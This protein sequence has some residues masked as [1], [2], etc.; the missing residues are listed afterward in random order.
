MNEKVGTALMIAVLIILAV[1]L[2]MVYGEISNPPTEHLEGQVIA[3]DIGRDM[4]I[5]QNNETGR[6]Y[7]IYSEYWA[8]TLDVGDD[9]NATVQHWDEIEKE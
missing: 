3:K 4:I 6:L 7:K 8:F 5:I 9:F 2:W 1:A